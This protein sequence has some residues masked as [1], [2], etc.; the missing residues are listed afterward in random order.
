[1]WLQRY[2]HYIAHLYLNNVFRTLQYATLK[3]A[4]RSCVV[5]VVKNWRIQGVHMIFVASRFSL[6]KF[7]R[8][9]SSI[10]ILEILSN[11]LISRRHKWRLVFSWTSSAAQV[12]QRARGLYLLARPRFFAARCDG[13]FPRQARK[14]KFRARCVRGVLKQRWCIPGDASLSPGVIS[15]RKAHLYFY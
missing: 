3:Y 8:V 12:L 14:W 10:A 1:M 9:T 4:A 13:R 2:Q 6:I 5:W 7:V 15:A 11:D